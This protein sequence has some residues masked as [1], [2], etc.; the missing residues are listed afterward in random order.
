MAMKLNKGQMVI[1]GM[2]AVVAIYAGALV[3]MN[4]PTPWRDIPDEGMSRNGLAFGEEITEM[5]LYHM[6]RRSFPFYFADERTHYEP[7]ARVGDPATIETILDMLLSGD[8]PAEPGCAPVKRDAMLHVITYR[9]DGS[10][11]G[12]VALQAGRITATG[13]TDAKDCTIAWLHQQDGFVS[14]E[15]YDFRTRL[16]E[17]TGV[18]M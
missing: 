4:E 12:Y 14:W 6:P 2:F 18:A 3:L 1:L 11:Y 15:T 16:T 5:R 9:A 8:P 7:L 10:V 17:I 13:P